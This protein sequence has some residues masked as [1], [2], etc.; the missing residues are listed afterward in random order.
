MVRIMS[1]L[2]SS[3]SMRRA[4]SF[5]AG[6]VI[7]VTLSA[8]GAP[9]TEGV[10]DPYE[11]QNRR[12]HAFNK[13]LDKAILRP[14]SRAYVAVL[15]PLAQESVSNFAGNLALPSS[16]VNNL[17]QFDLPAATKNT[18]RFAINSTF[19]VGGLFDPSGIMGLD[20]EESDF[21]ETLHVWGTPEGA[22]VE[23]PVFGP[24]T[25]RDA[26]GTVVDFFTNPLGYELSDDSQNIA[27]AARVADV[28]GTRGRFGDTVDSVLYESADSYAQ[29][30]LLYL[31]N[32]RF[33]LNGAES[34]PDEDP[35]ILNT[36]G[37]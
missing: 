3:R 14:V 5:F 22:Y 9:V 15:P 34:T 35:L 32:R 2:F 19:G 1:E 6:A 25:E 27:T 7:F 4:V 24:S 16:I 36:E 29:S 20:A 21:G 18:A 28:V 13:G 37:F 8:C 30:Q 33:E 23:L 31:Q 26:V 17:L 11:A 12:V 10:N